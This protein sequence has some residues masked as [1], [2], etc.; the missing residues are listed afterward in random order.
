MNYDNLNFDSILKEVYKAED[1]GRTRPA[2]KKESVEVRLAALAHLV[3]NMQ[4]EMHDI[5]Q[6]ERELVHA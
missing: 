4:N 1:E 5:V 6:N 2:T 3:K